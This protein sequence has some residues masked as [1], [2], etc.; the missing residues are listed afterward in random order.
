[1]LRKLDNLAV[2]FLVLSGF[3]WGVYGLYRLN[4]I[5][6]VFDRV[7]LIRIIY[8]SFGIAFIYHLITCRQESKKIKTKR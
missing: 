4:I 5:E 8:V 3:V 7:W 6:Y 1:M 2:L